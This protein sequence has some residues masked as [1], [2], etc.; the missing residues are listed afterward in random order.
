MRRILGLFALVVFA[1]P[2]SGQ[3]VFEIIACSVKDV[4]SEEYMSF[5]YLDVARETARMIGNLGEEE[6]AVIA[7]GTF[8]HLLEV[9]PQ[10]SL[11]TMTVFTDAPT[12]PA[13]PETGAQSV[14]A[15]YSRHHSI[16][17][18]PFASFWRGTCRLVPMPGR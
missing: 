3:V 10:G 5:N 18:E 15:V 8:L 13:D 14:S 2:V 9:T 12:S 16:F 17:G 4:E 11:M 7:R 6:V 1:S